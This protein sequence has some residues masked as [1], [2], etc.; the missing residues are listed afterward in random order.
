MKRFITAMLVLV[1][2]LSVT[3]CAA[4][5]PLIGTWRGTMD[6]S[7]MY[8]EQLQGSG[9]EDYMDLKDISFDMIM[10]FGEDQSIKMEADKASVEA[11]ADKLV[12]IMV[13]ATIQL[14]ESQNATLADMGVDEETLRESVAQSIN[15]ET[16][17]GSF[18]FES[19]NGY[20]L[21][22]DGKLYRADSVEE[23]EEAKAEGSEY[24]SIELKSGEFSLI[25]IVDGEDKF[26]DMAGN[27]LPITMKKQ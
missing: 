24:I 10:T 8:S 13:G 23:L 17:L 11:M 18:D 20:Y 21:Y 12:D 2:V 5:D 14:L 4:K 15:A 19:S 26:S 3:A 25:D 6:I 27:M 1:M 22:E 9:M 7:Q 16:L